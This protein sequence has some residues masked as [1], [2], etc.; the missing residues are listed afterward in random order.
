MKYLR[1]FYIYNSEE[2]PQR[3]EDI[4]IKKSIRD[5][6]EFYQCPFT[7]EQ[8]YIDLNN[9]RNA[10]EEPNSIEEAMII[11]GQQYEDS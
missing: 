3:S 5:Y 4:L 9:I 1:D 10:M 8:I 11:L 2:F 7:E 6:I